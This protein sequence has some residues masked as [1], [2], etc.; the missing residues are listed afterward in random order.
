MS[1]T[2]TLEDVKLLKPSRRKKDRIR[3]W[4][5]AL[6]SGEY[7]QG[8]EYLSFRNDVDL[9]WKHCCLGV[10][11]EVADLEVETSI[12]ESITGSPR[13]IRLYNKNGYDLPVSVIQW[14]GLYRGDTNG[15]DSDPTVRIVRGDRRGDRISLAGLNDGEG[16]TYDMIADLIERD[17]L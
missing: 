13:E 2:L 9:R 16:W 14:Y 7:V 12:Q 10:A 4:V 5:D 11:C 15:T 17:W 1:D 6:R 8:T 3:K